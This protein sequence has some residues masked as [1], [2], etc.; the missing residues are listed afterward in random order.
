MRFVILKG[1]EGFGDRLQCLLQ[2]IA[3]ARAT[4]RS[5][6]VDWRDNDWTHDPRHSFGHYFTLS[7]IQN[8]GIDPFLDY[9]N[10]NCGQ[11]SVHPPAWDGILHDLEF[12][13]F[14]YEPQ[15]QLEDDNER[16][17][18]IAKRGCPD[19]D[20]DIVVYPGTRV[21]N[22]SYADLDH[23]RLRK[24]LHDRI[25]RFLTENNLLYRQYDVVHLR[26]GS[27]R[28]AGGRVRLASL[29]DAIHKRWPTK[30]AYLDGL[31]QRYKQTA[32]DAPDPGRLVLVTDSKWLGEAWIA[33]FGSGRLLPETANQH[34][35]KSGTHKLSRIN[36]QSIGGNLC[37]ET[38]NYELI[39]DFV[40]MLNAR[41]TIGDGMSLFSQ[42]AASGN[43]LSLPWCRPSHQPHI[44]QPGQP[45]Q[46]GRDSARK[47]NN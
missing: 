30:E 45:G 28:W 14:V 11:L 25:R 23:I 29:A 26:G 42:M 8:L 43:A 31:Y 38:L 37:K 21:R 2:A 7:G 34:F 6:V 47:K 15:F 46:S 24:W 10:S 41:H 22:F 44:T 16:L 5:L 4:G 17:H 19:F 32:A 18:E 39:R 12:P 35:V 20:A 33:R 3:Y 36:L 40:I 9:L 27:K 1:V 13:D